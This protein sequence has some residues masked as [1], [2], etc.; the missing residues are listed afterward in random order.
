[1]TDKKWAI[2]ISAED[3]PYRQGLEEYWC[4]V[5]EAHEC[6]EYDCPLTRM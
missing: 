5:T 4:G 6:T 1:M 3:C 2:V